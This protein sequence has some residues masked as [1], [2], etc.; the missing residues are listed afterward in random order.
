MSKNEQLFIRL[1]DQYA[2][3]IYRFIFLKTSSPQDAEDLTSEVFFR[4]WKNNQEADNARALLYRIANNLVVDFYRKK[5]SQE[6]MFI[7]ANKG[8]LA[9]AIGETDLRGKAELDSEMKQI[10]QSLDKMKDEYQNIIIWHYL[11]DLSIKEI[12]QIL[13]KSQGTVRVLIHRALNSLKKKLK[14]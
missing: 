9:E 5:D 8:V 13:D 10:V 4:F 11:E 14:S 2:V 1:Y 12:A 3:Q 6:V 7:E